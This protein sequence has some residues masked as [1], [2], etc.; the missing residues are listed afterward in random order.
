MCYPVTHFIPNLQEL[1]VFCKAALDSN[2]EIMEGRT[3][4]SRH[5]R[6]SPVSSIGHSDDLVIPPLWA[7]QEN[8]WYQAL[9]ALNFCNYLWVK[10][11]AEGICLFTRRETLNAGDM[12]WFVGNTGEAGSWAGEANTVAAMW[13]KAHEVDKVINSIGA[14]DSLLGGMLAGMSKGLA[15][16]NG[17]YLDKLVAIGQ[18]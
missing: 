10:A 7:Y 9:I 4:D 14:G 18:R 3:V 11:G 13:F 16:E 12:A 6:L 2:P 8:L 15:P 5:D 17:Y 1:D